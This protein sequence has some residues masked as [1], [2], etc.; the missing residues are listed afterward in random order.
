VAHDDWGRERRLEPLDDQHELPRHLE[1]EQPGWRR[2]VGRITV[3]LDGKDVP[4][5]TAFDTDK[6]IVRVQR[7]DR[8]GRIFLEHDKVAQ[9]TKRGRVEVRWK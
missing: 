4:R 5:C 2:F 1:V 6:G 8:E 9:E 7:T 3:L